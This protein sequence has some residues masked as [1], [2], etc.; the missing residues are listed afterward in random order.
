MTTPLISVE[1]LIELQQEKEV[2]LVDVSLEKVVGMKAIEYSEFQVIP[3]SL[4]IN[5]NTELA[6]LTRPGNHNFP[7]KQQVHSCLN[8]IGYQSNKIIVLYDNQ[9]IYA[10]PRA[11]WIFASYGLTNVF[12]LDGGLP[13][14]IEYGKKTDNQYL[15]PDSENNNV[16]LNFNS[17]FISTKQYIADNLETNAFLLIDVRSAR[18]FSG[19]EEEPRPGVRSGHIPY[20][21]NLP[22]TNLFDNKRYK[23]KQELTNIFAG[24][25]VAKSKPLIFSCGSGITACIACIAA[26]VCGYQNVSLYDGSWTEWGSDPDMPIRS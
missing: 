7:N 6:D 26:K 3:N 15:T 2:L 13:A 23:T 8:R 22:F 17:D 5:L 24:I 10:S 4:Y 11:W 1:Q 25:P 18:R 9:G 14:W 21:Y 16:I 20:S 12:I 19:E